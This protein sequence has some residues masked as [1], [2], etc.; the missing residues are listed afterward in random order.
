M[1]YVLSLEEVR[2]PQRRI[3]GGK[4][5][6]LAVMAQQGIKVPATLI[7]TTRAYETFVAATGL[8]GRI[9]L[10][11]NRK[12]FEDLR[13][14]EMWDTSLRLRHLFLN[15]PMPDDLEASLK[16]ALGDRLPE[17]SVVRSSAPGEDSRQASFAGLHASFVNIA[18]L[19]SVLDHVKLVWASLWSDAAL[20]YR[21]G[22]VR[23]GLRAK[24]PG[25]LPGRH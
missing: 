25:P 17:R 19:R 18:G 15:T 22:H 23:R 3:V 7:V 8:R 14:E 4:G 16:R 1:N 12:S 11:L 10:E 6:C 24:P 20:L 21:R 2:P 9:L 5:Y 13:W